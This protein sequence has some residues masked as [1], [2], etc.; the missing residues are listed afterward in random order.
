VSGT[1][2]RRP[3]GWLGTAAVSLAATTETSIPLAV[4][5][6]V[7][8]IALDA[9]GL[10]NGRRPY[11]GDMP[12]QSRLIVDVTACHIPAPTAAVQIYE[13]M[14]RGVQVE[15]VTDGVLSVRAWRDALGRVSP[16]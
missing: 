14:R 7:V 2:Q 5:E 1:Q 9:E 12:A 13:A 8:R 11:F 15:I 6:F 3:G 16:W 4:A 10:L